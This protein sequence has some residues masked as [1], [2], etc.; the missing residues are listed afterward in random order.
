MSEVKVK[1]V[2]L[3]YSKYNKLNRYFDYITGYGPA[4]VNL[5]GLIETVIENPTGTQPA[6]F[7]KTGLLTGIIEEG[8]SFTW[9]DLTL[10]G[11]GQQGYV[12]LTPITGQFQASG[13]VNFNE[14]LLSNGDFININ[15]VRFTYR[16]NPTSLVDF[17]SVDNLINILNSGATGAF[18]DINTSISVVGVTG[19]RENNSVILF[20]YRNS[21]ADGN[22]VYMYRDCANLEAINIPHRYFRGGKDLQRPVNT[23]QGSFEN[24]FDLTV[25]NSGFYTT[26]LVIGNTTRNISGIFWK[27]SF[28]NYNISSGFRNLSNL[29]SYSAV[30]LNYNSSLNMYSGNFVFSQNQTRNPQR[31]NIDIVRLNPFDVKNNIIKYTLSG[32]DILFTGLLEG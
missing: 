19:Y 13:I 10:T 8:G 3:F 6:V 16:P 28:D 2:E 31:F 26:P 25:E 7:Y 29:I 17:N 24:T 4:F 20:A 27:N 12:Y 1:K 32:S 9:N 18:L 11:L 21:G 14:N 5:N 23:W 30:K 22:N 15:N